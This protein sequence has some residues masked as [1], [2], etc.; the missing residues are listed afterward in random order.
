MTDPLMQLL[1]AIT[2]LA[3]VVGILWRS[4]ERERTEQREDRNKANAAI[5]AELQ[6]QTDML[7][8][9]VERV[10]RIDNRTHQLA[11]GRGRVRTPTP[12]WPVGAAK[13][14]EDKEEP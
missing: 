5:T 8:R 1:A 9:L 10:I 3:G 13:P 11:G 14:D 6:V 12:F 4:W 7:R 2:A